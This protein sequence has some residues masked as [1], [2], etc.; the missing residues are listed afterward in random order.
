LTREEFIGVTKNAM[1]GLGFDQD[2]AMVVYPLPVFLVDSDLTP[3]V[4]SLDGLVDGLTEWQPRARTTGITKPTAIIVP[5]NGYEAGFDQANRLFLSNGWGDGLP[6]IPPSSARVAQTL[7]GTEKNADEVVGKVMPRGGIATV[8]TVAVALA[9][10]GGRPEYM[11]VLLGA[12]EAILAP[13]LGHD[14]FQATSGSTFPVIVVNGP[15]ADEIRLNSGFG[16]LGPDPQKPAGAA[17]GRALRL[18]LQNVGGALPGVGSMAIFGAMRYTNA[19]FAEDEAGLPDGW[20]PV[21]THY[22]GHGP[23]SNSVTVFVA[24]GAA[25]VMR[26]GVGK[27][28]PYTEALQGLLRTASY[29]DTAN[30]HY[31]RSWL[32]GT[33][34][35]LLIPRIVA[36][37]LHANGWKTK[38]SVREFLWERVQFERKTLIENGTLQW[39][40]AEPDAETRASAAMDP[41]PI[42]KSPEQLMIVVAG[43]EHPTHNFWL[44][45]W[46]PTVTGAALKLPSDWQSLL[47]AAD[48]E[49]GPAGEACMI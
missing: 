39:I 29:L 14:K 42:C 41:W 44:Q 49:L 13:E 18:L 1:A 2:L 47:D 15:I 9:M 16:C 12:M 24:T 20:E 11:P 6:L 25:N 37:Q 23:Q 22:L 8:E 40:E 17:I 36:Q 32:G 48:V 3:V 27:E 34:G 5:A 28:E 10:A 21:N 35:A 30:A 31:P 7:R 4:E 43:G 45:S 33:P 46:G 38:Q 26:R 19:V